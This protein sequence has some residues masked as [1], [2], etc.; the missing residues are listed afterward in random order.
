[1]KSIKRVKSRIVFKDD[2]PGQQDL[3]TGYL[4]VTSTFNMTERDF[5][6][7]NADMLVELETGARLRIKK[8]FIA[9]IKEIIVTAQL[10][11]EKK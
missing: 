1:M 10:V 7:R 2:F 5:L 3:I 11:E 4:D 8:E 6:D 9:Y